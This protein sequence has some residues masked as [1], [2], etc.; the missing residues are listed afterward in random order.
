[1]HGQLSVGL[2]DDR[3]TRLGLLGGRLGAGRER[4]RRLGGAGVG[5]PGRGGGGGQPRDAQE[6]EEGDVVLLGHPVE[7]VDHPLDEPGEELDQGH[8][9]VAGAGVGPLF[10]VTAD[11]GRGLVDEVLPGAIVQ[12]G[13]FELAACH[14]TP[15]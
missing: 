14:A 12:V 1:M 10:G 2:E 15:R 8:A 9:R 11:Q 4:D 7:A 6:V 5:Q 13:Y 3:R